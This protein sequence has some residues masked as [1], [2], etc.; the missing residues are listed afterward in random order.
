MQNINIKNS[1]DAIK[2]YSDSANAYSG[3]KMKTA[4]VDQLDA[5][6]KVGQV[7]YDRN[8]SVDTNAQTVMDNFNEYRK[9]MQE[10]AK[11]EQ[12]EETSDEEQA[13]AD[14]REIAR[15]LT[16]EEIKKLRM[17]GVDVAS[18]SLSDI[19][20]LVTSMRA[21]AR[22]DALVNVLAQAQIEEGDA[23]NLVFT[24][25]GAQIAGT[26][27]K[28]QVG[29]KDILYLLKNRQPL[30]QETLYKAHYSGQREIAAVDEL[31]GDTAYAA[32]QAAQ[33]TISRPQQ[34]AGQSVY[35]SG[36]D[37]NADSGLQAQLAHVIMQAGFVVD[38]TSMAG[39]NL[40]LANDIPVTT[41]SVRAL[42]LIH[43]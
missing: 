24:S 28:L 43:I 17:M 9:D 14:A 29:N 42:S 5:F 27:V 15:S 34:S 26:D 7:Q 33:Q 19:E 30:T 25:S 20:G 22:K 12:Q 31:G 35:A 21:D 32:K 13:R 37:G 40:L 1:Q 23:S 11:Q 38:E 10:K 6:E 36:E 2:A 16:S 4:S 8:S 41:D 3:T 18:A 39:A